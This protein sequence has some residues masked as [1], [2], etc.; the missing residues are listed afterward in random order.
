M[1]KVKRQTLK[2]QQQQIINA[3]HDYDVLHPETEASIVE[4]SSK[5][6]KSTNV[7]A[8][9]DELYDKIES[10]VNGVRDVQ[11]EGVSV[12]DEDGVANI[13]PG[14][15]E[16]IPDP[17]DPES[18]PPSFN[19]KTD[20]LGKLSDVQTMLMLTAASL[21]KSFG[22]A[23]GG[24]A[25]TPVSSTDGSGS[26]TVTLGGVVASP[27]IS[28]DAG[29]D[30][31]GNKYHI[32]NNAELEQKAQAAV[33]EAA[34]N[35]SAAI[36]KLVGDLETGTQ[37]VR[38]LRKYNDTRVTE[39]TLPNILD[40]VDAK[41]AGKVGYWGTADNLSEVFVKMANAMEGDLLRITTQFA[42]GDDIA[43]VGDMII[44]KVD[45]PTTVADIKV[46]HTEIDTNTWTANSKTANGYVAKGEGN[47]GKFWGTDSEGN[48]GWQNI[49]N[50]FTR[51]GIQYNADSGEF[52]IA[53]DFHAEKILWIETIY[54]DPDKETDVASAWLVSEYQTGSAKTNDHY[55]YT[56]GWSIY[57]LYN[58]EFRP[59]ECTEIRIASMEF[60]NNKFGTPAEGT[61]SVVRTNANGVVQAGGSLIEVGADTTSEPSANLVVGGI[62]FKPIE[63]SE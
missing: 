27:T 6:V 33:A 46:A 35:T 62:F 16:I 36:S 18:T 8:A 37:T 29:E 51:C 63:A 28:I 7:E 32:V 54:D 48:P 9:I 5:K 15:I 60:V 3:E 47:P 59:W 43:H 31:E 13:I 56:D 42:V 2:Y 19:V 57:H 1:A 41:S 34:G 38:A 11:V 61:Y 26:V 50:P 30:S 40:Y 22:E 55:I 12:T 25:G 44:A 4:L 52:I 49:P 23:I 39:G 20:G 17:E 14:E 21:S 45:K 58:H 10:Q 53:E 24:L